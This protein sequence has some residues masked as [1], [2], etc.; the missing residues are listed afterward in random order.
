V[1]AMFFV[2]LERMLNS[3]VVHGWRDPWLSLTSTESITARGGASFV[4]ARVKFSTDS[5]SPCVYDN[6]CTGIDDTSGDGE[7]CS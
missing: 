4:T 6:A 2:L 7:S 5:S 1:L 3:I